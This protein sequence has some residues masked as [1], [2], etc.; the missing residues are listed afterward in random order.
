M[1]TI[2][3][4]EEVRNCINR[5]RSLRKGFITN[6]FPEQRK[7]EIWTNHFLLFA[8]EIEEAT[9]FI[10]QDEGFKYLFYCATNKKSLIEVLCSL[11]SNE[12]Y[13]VNQIVDSRTDASLIESFISS[14]YVVR[15]SLVRMSKIN[16]E[17]ELAE[18]D[19]DFDAKAEDIHILNSMLHQYFDKYAEQ[20][21]SEEE[22]KDFLE[23]KHAIVHRINNQIAGLILYDQ[24]PST[25]Y[26]RYWLVNPE[27]RN[28]GVGSILIREYNRRGA[29]CK[30]HMLWVVED[31]DNAIKRYKH[32]GYK[33]EKMKDYVLTLNVFADT[34]RVGGGN[35][36]TINNML[37]YN[38]KRVA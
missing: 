27:F 38:Y 3:S 15:K 7:V 29:S 35:N 13:V 5:V 34:S 10:K 22:M 26:L 25:L 33:N 18:S 30:R 12:K 17:A 24:T 16:K 31:N 19:S 1:I 8:K 23:A 36:L 9:L 2:K 4:F 11:P 21:P 6:F 37:F 32:Y 14:G 20:L 28:Q